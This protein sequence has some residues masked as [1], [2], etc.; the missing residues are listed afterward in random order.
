MHVA[1]TSMKVGVTFRRMIMHVA[2]T[3][4]KVGVTSRRMIMHV[5]STS[6]KVGG[7]PDLLHLHKLCMMM[8]VP[9]DK[10]VA[11]ST[12]GCNMISL[13]IHS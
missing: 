5:A 3:S 10:S 11:P 4:L 1:S 9:M 12:F 13:V 7:T 6:M 2:S 8:I